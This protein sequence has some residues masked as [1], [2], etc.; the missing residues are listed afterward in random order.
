MK[1]N[2]QENLKKPSH[3]IAL[4]QASHAHTLVFGER[5]RLFPLV[6]TAIRR[7]LV[8]VRVRVR[9]RVLY[10]HQREFPAL[11][12]LRD[13]DCVSVIISLDRI[14]ILDFIEAVKQSRMDFIQVEGYGADE[15]RSGGGG[16][17]AL[18]LRSHR[19]G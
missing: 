2:Q 5:R 3:F 7:V 16:D 19:P 12:F 4:L 1:D 6:P 11:K 15:S 14:F 8:R 9:V 18:P 10:I 13:E 17:T